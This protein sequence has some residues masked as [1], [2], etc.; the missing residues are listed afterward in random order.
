MFE[1]Q[2]ACSCRSSNHFDNLLKY[3]ALNA[4]PKCS[5]AYGPLSIR[6]KKHAKENKSNKIYQILS[7]NA[8]HCQK[9]M[10]VWEPEGLLQLL[11]GE[12]G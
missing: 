12:V 2:G 6:I 10:C 4:H 7:K 1:S 11:V 5:Y 8:R 9:N 3:V